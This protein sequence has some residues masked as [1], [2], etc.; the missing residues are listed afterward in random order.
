MLWLVLIVSVAADPLLVALIV[1]SLW[2]SWSPRHV[3]G[4]RIMML[5]AFL[6]CTIAID[7]FIASA[8]IGPMPG[9]LG[10]ARFICL[11]LATALYTLAFLV[12]FERR[13]RRI[14]EQTARDP[15]FTEDE[16]HRAAHAY[17]PWMRPP[18]REDQSR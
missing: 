15:Q 4:A 11:L 5:L 9:D 14:I 17:Q 3:L 12:F 1:L 8:I 6:A 10:A 13:R 7:N 2:A 18:A 16:E